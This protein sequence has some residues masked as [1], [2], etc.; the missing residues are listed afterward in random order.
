LT[1]VGLFAGIGGIELGLERSGHRT[2]LFCEIDPGATEVLRTR[3]DGIP[4][5]SDVTQLRSLPPSTELLTAGFPCQD[6]SQAGR[7]IGIEGERS[8]LVGEAFRLLRRK[9]VPWVL[10]ENVS[11]MLQLQRG[12]AL[13]KI[14]STLEE[15][16]YAWAYRVLDSRFTGIPQRRERIYILA[17]TTGDPRSVLLSEDSSAGPIQERK[18]WWEAPCGFYWTEGV[19]GLGWAFNAVPTL[20]GG[21]T[22]GI[23][24]PP[25]IIL[26]SGSIRK[27]DIRDAER[28]QGFEP[29][30]TKPA[31]LV[32][33]A[34]YRWKLVGN[35]V[36]VD[37]AQWIG[38]RLVEP[39][40]Y[41]DATDEVLESGSP[42][43]KAAWGIGG[44]RYRSSA[45]AWPRLRSPEGLSEFL[46]YETTPLSVKAA[47]GFMERAQRS[48][49][50]FPPRFLEAVEHHIRAFA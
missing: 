21:S 42:W 43:P 5:R 45:S 25:A 38:N 28:L 24:S 46:R 1:T 26:P 40:P 41:D 32:C 10:L 22:V 34:G 47:S 48:S 23:P 8:G 19:R 31:E 9:R 3:F 35:A 36:T 37:V 49:L 20:K 11:F 6:L 2:A 7:T 13:E 39:I 12:D 14:V 17:S 18:E 27:P 33:R 16:G 50:R 4:I 30:W 29:D 44:E 15:L